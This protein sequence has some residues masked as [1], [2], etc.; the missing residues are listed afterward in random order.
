MAVTSDGTVYLSGDAGLAR[1][2]GSS[3]TWLDVL[4][5]RRQYTSNGVVAGPH[6]RLVASIGDSTML[7]DGTRWAVVDDLPFGTGLHSTY[8]FDQDGELWRIARVD[9][10]GTQLL[11][12]F[13]GGDWVAIDGDHAW[14]VLS[15]LQEASDWLSITSDR[16]LWFGGR[17]GVG[18]IPASE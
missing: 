13:H 18:R 1:V 5:D 17:A 14:G 7:Y 11:E 12:R 8:A 10:G 2:S 6:G 16:T 15:A 4:G 3:C 9:R